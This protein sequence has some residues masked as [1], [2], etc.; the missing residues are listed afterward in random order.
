MTE[1]EVGVG[2]D[3]VYTRTSFVARKA[4]Y[5]KDKAERGIAFI[6]EIDKIARKSIDPSITRDGCIA[7]HVKCFFFRN[8]S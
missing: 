7:S 8:F 3:V 4:D 6:D 2:E 5:D 1:A